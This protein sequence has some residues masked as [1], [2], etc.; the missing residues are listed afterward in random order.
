[1]TQWQPPE[2]ILHCFDYIRMVIMCHGDTALEGSDPFAIARNDTSGTIGLGT[3][4]ICKNWDELLDWTTKKEAQD[5]LD[6]PDPTNS[7][8]SSVSNS[9]S[10]R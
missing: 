3:T 10:A 7:A 6:Y 5:L 1:M 4:H 2:H 8:N 9:S